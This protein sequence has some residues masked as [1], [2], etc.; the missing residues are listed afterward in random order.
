MSWKVA[1]TSGIGGSAALLGLAGRGV[2]AVQWRRE[3]RRGIQQTSEGSS[4][5]AVVLGRGGLLV[6]SALGVREEAVSRGQLLR[7]HEEWVGGRMVSEVRGQ[8]E[9]LGLARAQLEVVLQQAVLARARVPP[10]FGCRSAPAAQ[11]QLATEGGG[12]SPGA[13]GPVQ[14]WAVLG[15]TTA[16]VAPHIQRYWG[17]HWRLT[18]VP[19]G[20][21]Q[22]CLQILL[23]A[24]A[25]G[26]S[27]LHRR[28]LS[29]LI[30][31]MGPHPLL[32]HLD[33]EL[34]CNVSYPARIGAQTTGHWDNP[35]LAL[36][37]GATLGALLGKALN[38]PSIENPEQHAMQ[39]WQRGRKP[40]W[41]WAAAQQV[42]DEK[43]VL[44][45]NVLTQFIRDLRLRWGGSTS[46]GILR[47]YNSEQN[48]G[49][50]QLETM[51]KD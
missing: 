4:G 33:P 10:R 13:G 41:D 28:P 1:V 45:G 19:V 5:E 16:L 15:S 7:G 30:T 26:Q 50:S 46:R 43:R 18:A 2:Q 27:R 8:G 51:L 14:Q 34:L 17:S 24:P 3:G 9:R 37:D 49:I 6:L 48:A 20:P 47:M 23:P 12:E 22:L 29:A 32:D 44:A 21:R 38:D 35:D 42:L 39:L 40:R 25:P 36:E 11:V 31:A